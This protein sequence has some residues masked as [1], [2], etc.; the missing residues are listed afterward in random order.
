[1][2]DRVRVKLSR[3]RSAGGG[4]RPGTHGVADIDYPA[5][6]TGRF[7]V[8]GSGAQVVAAADSVQA[9]AGSSGTAAYDPYFFPG[10]FES[11]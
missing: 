10:F 4:A 1:M 2:A 8:D 6:T 11:N 9:V 3:W 7:E 5:G